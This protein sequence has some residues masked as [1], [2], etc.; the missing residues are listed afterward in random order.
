MLALCD[1]I[2]VNRKQRATLAKIFTKP[3]P[4]DLRWADVE[5]LFRAL[6]AE[7]EPCGGS[8][9]SVR[10]SGVRAVFHKP[11]PSPHTDKG[12]VRAVRIF[13]ETAGVRP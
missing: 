13:L 6:G 12:A 4:A 11:H 10:L 7:I 2:F 9:V 8:M 1:T 3:A 5:T